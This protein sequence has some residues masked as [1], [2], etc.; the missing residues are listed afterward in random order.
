VDLKYHFY[1][2]RLAYFGCTTAD[3]VFPPKPPENLNITLI[4]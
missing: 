4:S 2:P 1:H 3:S